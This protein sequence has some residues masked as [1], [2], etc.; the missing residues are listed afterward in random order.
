MPNRLILFSYLATYIGPHQAPELNAIG[1][2]YSPPAPGSGAE[3][4]WSSGV[5]SARPLLPESTNTS[6]AQHPNNQPRYITAET[7][8][9]TG[10]TANQ[11]SIQNQ[12]SATQPAEQNCAETARLELQDA[13]TG[14]FNF[15]YLVHRLEYEVLRNQ[16][17]GGQLSVI[18]V[19]IDRFRDIGI[20]YGALSLDSSMRELARIAKATVRELD[21]TGTYCEGKLIIVCPHTPSQTA[22][23][24][25]NAIAFEVSKVKLSH[26]WHEFGIRVSCG[27]SALS[28][29]IQD[30][31]SL[32]ALADVGS[33]IAEKNQS[34]WHCEL[35]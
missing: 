3:R 25:C 22:K 35:D 15:A 32:I 4:D 5:F 13:V 11:Q 12:I 26:Q 2:A 19:S 14:A 8:T 34:I 16:L 28:N 9:G 27:I 10:S 33:E 29:E 6:S 23:D 1:R 17:V 7:P 21:L 18:V 20:E 24:L 30:A 31:E